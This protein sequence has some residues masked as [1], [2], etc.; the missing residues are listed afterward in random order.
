MG[1]NPAK[2]GGS[3]PSGGAR[4]GEQGGREGGASPLPESA[5]TAVTQLSVAD[6]DP[7]ATLLF[8][9]AGKGNS[10]SDALA[11]LLTPSEGRPTMQDIVSA[12]VLGTSA[13][14]ASVLHS[15]VIQRAAAAGLENPLEAI[16][17]LLLVSSCVPGAM[18]EQRAKHVTSALASGLLEFTEASD[19][20]GGGDGVLPSRPILQRWLNSMS[21]ACVAFQKRL[22]HLPRPPPHPQEAPP[23]AWLRGARSGDSFSAA[24]S[25]CRPTP[26]P[27]QELECTLQQ[28]GVG[29][30]F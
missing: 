16:M 26:G 17:A 7:V 10:A 21:G 27:V 20:G 24:S 19:L 9:E 5:R 11:L 13:E 4:Q 23:L 25:P 30:Q 8:G 6:C 2:G 29:S 3:G 12:V 14:V 1:N 28:P 15:H 22:F 18:N